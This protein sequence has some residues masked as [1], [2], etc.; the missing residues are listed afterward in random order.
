MDVRML[1][2][3]VVVVT[4]VLVL[5]GTASAAAS[6]AASAGVRAGVRAGV[7]AGAS[8]AGDKSVA[9]AGVLT[10]DDFAPG[11]QQE[12]PDPVDR[13]VERIARGIPSCR[14]YLAVR[15]AAHKN[16]RAKSQDFVQGDDE[17]SNTVNVFSAERAA[18]GA[19]DEIRK[20]SIERCLRTVFDKVISAN[21]AEDPATRKQIESVEVEVGRSDV[22]AVGDEA[23]AFEIV[24]RVLTKTGDATDL[25]LV[26]EFVR[27]GR[28][29]ASFN[30]QATGQPLTDTAGYIDA[31]VGRLR[32]ALA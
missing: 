19:L 12:R 3:A 11:W 10:A 26:Q 17:V 20:P 30:F 21:I 27:V 31:S 5:L 1:E 23:L 15:T 14:G 4:S 22:P 8:V 6:A 29:I 13:D 18:T 32:T 25:Y 2:K 9:K 24:V 28:A 16:P 7:S